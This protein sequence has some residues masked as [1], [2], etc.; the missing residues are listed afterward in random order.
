MAFDFREMIVFQSDSLSRYQKAGVEAVVYQ[1]SYLQSL[2]QN[3]SHQG[4]I[5]WNFLVEYMQ[6]NIKISN[7]CYF[8]TDIIL[9]V[10]S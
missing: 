8:L 10:L 2:E 4:G 3:K 7:A 1:G 5:C 6:I 9:A